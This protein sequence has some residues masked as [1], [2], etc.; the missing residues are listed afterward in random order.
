MRRLLY[1]FALK[2]AV[3]HLF[4]EAKKTCWRP[5]N[6][7]FAQDLA[8]LRPKN[9]TTLFPCPWLF[10]LDGVGQPADAGDVD[11]DSISR[12]QGEIVGGDDAGAGEEDG[13]MGK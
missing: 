2:I 7:C 12:G 13:P 9:T 10:L 1:L 6:A 3:N 11:V 4:G 5:K 8:T